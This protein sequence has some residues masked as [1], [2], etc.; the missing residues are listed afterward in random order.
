MSTPSLT[1]IASATMIIRCED[2]RF[3]LDIVVFAF[4]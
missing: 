4:E 1:A 3:A 2:Y